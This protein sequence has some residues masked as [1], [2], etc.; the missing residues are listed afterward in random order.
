MSWLPYDYF[1]SSPYEVHA[2]LE[3]YFNKEKKMACMMRFAS[4]RIHQSLCGDKSLSINE[5]WPIEEFEEH[6]KDV[7]VADKEM[8]DKIMKV[9]KFKNNG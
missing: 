1:T 8:V 5:Y 3:G 4:F 6:T 2:A 7:F 9:H